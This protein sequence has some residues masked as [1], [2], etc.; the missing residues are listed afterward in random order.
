MVHLCHP[1][2]SV[3]NTVYLNLGH[4]RH[5]KLETGRSQQH[6]GH[7][8]IW[9]SHFYNWKD[10]FL[11]TEKMSPHFSMSC[12]HL[13]DIHMG[14]HH[15]LCAEDFRCMSLGLF[16]FPWKH[17]GSYHTGICSTL[18]LWLYDSRTGGHQIHTQVT[19][20]PCWKPRK[21]QMNS[22]LLNP[23]RFDLKKKQKNISY[24]SRKMH[25]SWM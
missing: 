25:N 4:F 18:V 5:K 9:D 15:R 23:R 13:V 8:H 17:H 22:T 1:W 12:I 10:V 16:S 7:F 11:P 2:A 6:L 24:N 21:M 3:W 20:A 19:L 14:I